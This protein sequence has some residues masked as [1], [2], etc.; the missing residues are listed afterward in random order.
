VKDLKYKLGDFVEFFVSPGS[1]ILSGQI[2]ATDHN[3]GYNIHNYSGLKYLVR[4]DNSPNKIAN[5]TSSKSWFKILGHYKTIK[6][7]SQLYDNDCATWMS[8]Q[9][10]LAVTSCEDAP[11]KTNGAKC[12]KCSMYNEWADP[13]QPDGKY[14][15]YNCRS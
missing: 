12:F 1:K 3:A 8:A 11:T 15:C 6:F 14:L 13:N 10:I 9:Q 5:S 7:H 2:I 4:I